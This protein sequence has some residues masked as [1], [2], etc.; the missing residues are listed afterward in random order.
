MSPPAPFKPRVLIVDDEQI[1]AMDLSRIVRH[2]GYEVVAMA[3]SAAEAL[4]LAA[5]HQPDVVLMDINLESGGSGIDAARE[6]R[7]H[8]RT[9]IVFAT[10]YHDEE[11][12]TRATLTQPFG[13]V[14]KPFEER[15]VKT[16]L[17]LALHLHAIEQ[18]R[19]RLIRELRDALDHV[20]VLSGLIP[21]CAEC[22]K[23]RDDKGYW[24]SVELYVTKRTDARFTHGVCPECAKKLMAELDE[25]KRQ[26]KG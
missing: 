17:A 23:V 19:E 1:V 4:T 7:E 10:A 18:D 8:W 22:K 12:L 2:L 16:A 20:R 14:V 21:I 13:Y 9:P 5:E 26:Q 6:I 15:E 24:E 25:M 3:A 11:T